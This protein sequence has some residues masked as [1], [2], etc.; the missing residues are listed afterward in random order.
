MTIV[1]TRATRASSFGTIESWDPRVDVIRYLRR[2]AARWRVVAFVALVCIGGAAAATAAAIPEY[3]TNATFFV[4]S[5]S[6]SQDISQQ[7]AAAIYAQQQVL[8][9]A[10]V[11]SS[12]VMAQTV[13]SD[14]NLGMSAAEIRSEISTSV[15]LGTVLVHVTVTDTSANRALA[16]LQSL[17]RSYDAV[18]AKVDAANNTNTK[19]AYRVSVTLLTNPE[20]P[21]SPS[22]PNVL[23]NLLVGLVAGLLLGVGAGALREVLDSRINDADRLS[24]VTG[25]PTMGVVVN[26]PAASKQPIATR[27]GSRSIRAENFRQIRANLQFANVDEHP[28]VIVIT[29]SIPAEG[30]TMVALN[31]ASTLAEAGFT[32][33]LVDADLRRP[34]IAK[35]MGLPGAVGLTS[36]LINQIDLDEAMQNAGSNLFVLTSGPIP[37]NPSEVLASSFVREIIRSL[38]DKVDYVII[39]TAPL[40]PVADGAEVAALADGVLLVARNKLTTDAQVKRAVGVLRRVDAKLIGVVLNRVL[41]SRR[42]EYGYTYY[43]ESGKRSE[44]GE[45]SRSRQPGRRRKE[46]NS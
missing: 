30:K 24:E 16:I 36:V 31:L 25:K 26:D 1:D 17:G 3:Q 42:G 19:G 6:N 43:G 28:R 4:S 41:A 38:L 15:E 5:N 21:T 32:V 12:E 14:L 2:I 37:P 40:L 46:I 44:K 22:S 45:R 11:A 7:Q 29:S 8:S 10:A 35:V 27:A 9:Y 23:L 13:K 33:C 39:D 18:I 34:S 20:F